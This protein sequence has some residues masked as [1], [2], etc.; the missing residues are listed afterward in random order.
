MLLRSTASNAGAARR[1]TV[2]DVIGGDPILANT[3][4]ADAL[5][6]RSLLRR[7]LEPSGEIAQRAMQQHAHRPG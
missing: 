7:T 3:G 1:F 4:E 2:G 5:Q 6:V